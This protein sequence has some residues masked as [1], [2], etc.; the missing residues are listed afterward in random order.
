MDPVTVYFA[1][2]AA[3]L[4]L[5][6][7]LDSRDKNK[8]LQQS[9]NNTN[10]SN[11]GKMISEED[12][13]YSTASLITN[14]KFNTNYPRAVERN[15]SIQRIYTIN[16]VYKQ[17]IEKPDSIVKNRSTTPEPINDS[18]NAQHRRKASLPGSVH[19]SNY[20][21][22]DSNNAV[23]NNNNHTN[24]HVLR[25]RSSVHQQSAPNIFEIVDSPHNNDKI[26]PEQTRSKSLN[27]S[28]T[29]SPNVETLNPIIPNLTTESIPDTGVGECEKNVM[30]L[31]FSYDELL[32]WLGSNDLTNLYPIL[33]TLVEDVDDLFHL[34]ECENWNRELLAKEL[35]ISIQEA[36]KLIQ[37]LQNDSTIAKANRKMKKKLLNTFFEPVTTK[38][39]TE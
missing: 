28:P 23:N 21:N 10:K 36:E 7:F 9:I 17:S 30:N 5:T 38:Q 27:S 35:N 2:S 12:C 34:V 37:R 8:Q 18:M 26:R 25:R 32:E 19:L 1:G 39:H 24:P 6:S 14:E 3:L 20:T 33:C 29:T 15:D 31:E 22:N 11:I 13:R 16:N 4:A